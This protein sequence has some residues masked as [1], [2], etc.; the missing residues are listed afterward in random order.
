MNTVSMPPTVLEHYKVHIL[1]LLLAF[2]GALTLAHPMFFVNDEWITGNQLAQLN[3]GH[4]VILNEGKYGSFEN[5]TPTMYFRARQNSLGYTLFLPIISLPAEWMVYGMGD[6][7]VFLILYLSTFLL[8]AICLLINTYFSDYT[9]IG[10]WRWTDGLLIF[11]FIL[12]F[13]NLYYYIPFSTTGKYGFPE[14][15]A[16]VFTNCL[17]FSIIAVIAY[18]IVRLI[19]ED[20]VFSFFG[21]I[22]CLTSS[23]YLFWSSFCKDHVLVA[24]VFA[25]V[26]LMAV[27]FWKTHDIRYLFAAF[28]FSGL[29]AW[30]RPELALF[31]CISLCV[32]VLYLLIRKNTGVCLNNRLSI[33]LAPA[34]TILGAI[35]LL[36]NN[37]LVT[38]NPLRLPW[39]VWGLP[40]SGT[41]A[42][43]SGIT[44]GTAVSA[45]QD[46][47]VV[48]QSR[49]IISQTSFHQDL[50][51]ILFNPQSGSLA[52]FPL[53]PLFFVALFLVPVLIVI[54]KIRFSPEEKQ[55]LGIMSLLSISVFIAYIRNMNTMNIDIGIA[56]DMRYLSPLYL[57]LNIIGLVILQKTGI[58]S[59][60]TF[61]VLKGMVAVW[62]IGICLTLITISQFFPAADEGV[63]QLSSIHPILNVWVTIAVFILA[64][65]VLISYMGYLL[66][67]KPRW[68]PLGF[69]TLLISVPFIWQIDVSFLARV[70]GYSLGGYTFWIPAIR[71][72]FNGIF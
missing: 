19:F 33:I 20:P 4:Q 48:V 40:S 44:I 68:V 28:S 8:I 36:L 34:F 18:D 49:T 64:A 22:V 10:K 30:A 11:A 65:L 5:G 21:V 43:G 60:K 46:I 56:P 70:Y 41:V 27:R 32:I 31:V 29:L 54:Q 51:G 15:G 1:V 72:F 26:V 52:V 47:Q 12:F 7:F 2:L 16:I 42:T 55:L 17:L 63:I 66:F 61:T 3:E 23:S 9:K 67:Q 6:N 59:G 57:P 39:S 35:P 58:L 24:C 62:L 69:L 50:F 71:I 45:V 53:V 14:V 13:I 37:Y 25:A 38:G